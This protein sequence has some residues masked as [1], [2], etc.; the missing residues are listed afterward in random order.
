MVGEEEL[1]RGK[2]G[3]GKGGSKLSGENPKAGERS[4]SIKEKRVS[5]AQVAVTSKK[6]AT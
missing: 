4:A 2:G 3:M 5:G 1:G 6:Q